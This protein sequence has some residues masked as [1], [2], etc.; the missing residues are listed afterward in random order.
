MSIFD[1]FKGIQYK[2]ELEKANNEIIEM[3]KLFTPEM[4]DADNLRRAIESLTI[5]KNELNETLTET[6]KKIDDAN[7]SLKIKRQQLVTL[8]EEI[9]MQDF[10]L[11]KPR[12]DFATSAQYKDKLDEIRE[13]QKAMIKAGKAVNGNTNWTVNNNAAKGQKM[14]KDTQ[15]LLL[16]AFN[17]DCDEAISKVKYNNFDASLKRIT[18]SKEAI[19]KLGTV[20]NISISEEY[21]KL[22]TAELALAFEYQQKKQEEKE[23]AKYLREQLRE[24]AKLKKEIE[25]ARKNIEKEQ[26]HYSNA[27]LNAQKS[28]NNATTDEEKANWQEKIDELKVHLEDVQ[29][30]LTDIDYREANKRAGYVYI[31]SNIGSFGENVYKIGMTRRLDPQERIDELGDASVP[32]NFD[33]HAMIF[34]DDAPKLEAA[35]HQEF[36]DRKLN[37]VN[38]RREFFNVTLEEIEAAVRNN[39]EKSVDFIKLPDAEQYRESLKIK[40]QQ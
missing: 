39:F 34:S 6:Q 33:V 9:L 14:V 31:I 17:S 32:F 28:Y 37:M 26:K 30:N 1:V 4:Q 5:E 27:L 21:Y 3:K 25:E 2:K 10:G 20:M 11:Y 15:K 24:E 13:K 19:S 7:E 35:L 38:T 18:S 23:E 29:K 8:D 36:S 16:R 12:F 40:Q 22:K